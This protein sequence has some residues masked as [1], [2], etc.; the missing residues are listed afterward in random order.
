MELISSLILF[1]GNKIKV[2]IIAIIKLIE[3]LYYCHFIKFT[4]HVL[5]T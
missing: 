3:Y 4:S 5:I 2:L 1:T